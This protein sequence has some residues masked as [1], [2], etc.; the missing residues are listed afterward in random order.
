MKYLASLFVFTALAHAS[1][2]PLPEAPKP[3]PHHDYLGISL[4][5]SEA[6][7]RTLDAYSTVRAN[8]CTCNHETSLPQ[9]WANHAPI[10]FGYSGGIV[11]VNWFVA[12]ELQRHGHNKLARIPYL[13]DIGREAPLMHNFAL[14]AA[15]AAN[16]RH[17]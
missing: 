6:S 8:R 16:R 14:P 12:R 13:I 9:S 10:M 3:Q 4:L 1:V 17:Q 7:L 15:T 2:A 5:A 11:G